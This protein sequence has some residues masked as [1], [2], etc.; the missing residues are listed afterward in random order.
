[1]TL[2]AQL[3]AAAS[4]SDQDLS[5]IKTGAGSAPVLALL[6]S[7]QSKDTPTPA[8][9]PESVLLLSHT[10]RY[11]L[12]AEV[13]T[14]TLHV[15]ERDTGGG[16]V[17]RLKIP[18][19]IGKQ[20]YGKLREGDQ[21]TP[22]GVYRFTSYLTEKQLDDFYGS[23]AYPVNYP[24]AL[25][26]IYGRTGSGIWLHGLPFD[27]VS[28]PKL[29]S[30]GCVV[31]DNDS[32][33]LMADY[34]DPGNSFMVIGETLTWQNLSQQRLVGD[35]ISTAFN[36]WL[37]AWQSLDNDKYLSYYAK[38]FTNLKKDLAAWKKYKR[39][40]HKNKSFIDVSTSDM[41]IFS[42]PGDERISVRYYQSYKSSNYRWRGWK[43]QLW[44]KEDDGW[45]IVYE[46][47]G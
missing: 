30:D 7:A 3:W 44:R 32:V 24:N 40:I 29:D 8:Q 6:D 4:D 22:L 18:M 5:S 42:I 13:T 36:D 11:L 17:T 34:I 15:L 39:R 28:R 16:M 45:K 27:V 46:G 41:S 43:E 14:G 9:M 1:M 23:G 35:E 31:I 21:R 38:D 26:K 2:C 20:G 25:D 19:S 47:D 37:A 10:Y 12:W 33:D